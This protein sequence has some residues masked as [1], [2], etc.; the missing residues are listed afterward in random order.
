MK[1]I[2]LTLQAFGPYLEKTVIDFSAF[3]EAGLF[4]ISGP[5]GG[6]KTALLDAV[7]FALYGR[8]TGGRRTF[9]SMRCM[10][11]PQELPTLVEYEFSLGQDTYLFRRTRASHVHRTTKEV[12]LRDSHECY[13]LEEGQWKLLESRSDSAVRSRAESIL[14]ITGDQFSQVIVLP[15]GDFLR[16]LRASSKEKGEMLQT[17]FSAERWKALTDRLSSR[18]RALEDKL[19]ELEARRNSL[20]E[21]EGLENSAALSQAAEDSAK[22]E[23][24]LRAENDTL[25]QQA[26]KAQKELKEAEEWARLLEAKSSGEAKAGEALARCDLLAGQEKENSEKRKQAEALRVQAVKAAQELARLEEKKQ[27]AV[28]A[29]ETARQA[30][31][32]R[33]ALLSTQA[34]LKEF[35]QLSQDRT[36]RLKTGEAYIREC[37]EA[38][39]ALP[40]LLE[41]SHRL[42]KIRSDYGELARRR[43]EQ[44]RAFTKLD[45]AKKAAE[46]KEI[47]LSALSRA[48]AH[49]EEKLRHNTALELARTLTEGTPCPVCGS[50]HHPDPRKGQSGMLDQKELEAL[51]TREKQAREESLSA[52]SAAGAAEAQWKQAEALWK[53]QEALCGEFGISL[54]QAQVDDDALK[55]KLRKTKEKAELLQK[56]QKRMDELNREREEAASREAALREKLSGQKAKAEE[57]ERSA[58][59]ALE[60]LSGLDPEGLDRALKEK[61]EHREELE[62]RAAELQR[63]AELWEADRQKAAEANR[64]AEEALEKVKSDLAAFSGGRALGESPP[65]LPALKSRAAELREESLR[66]SEE[67][68]KAGEA[69]LSLKAALQ[70]VQALEA[71]SGRQEKDYS[72]AARLAR[73]LRGDNSQKLPILQ[74]VLSMM[75][76]EVLASANRFFSNL[77]RGRYRLQLMES[78]RGGNA[79]SGLDLEVA[80][81]A[82]ML[83][84]SIETL[85]GGEQFLASLSLAFGLSEVVQN[86]SGAV[87]MDA[88]FIDEGFGSLDSETLDTA[89]KALGML[90][91]SGR[92]VG[93]ISHVSELK[94]RLPCRIEVTRDEAGFSHAKINT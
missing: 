92:M 24:S 48:L 55:E 53:E 52:G 62:R 65:D 40:A 85:S 86:H 28:K 3:E 43:E 7:S 60:S 81:G 22:R 91:G 8:A 36:K 50:T 68:G 38:S 37:R 19:K 25:R 45:A 94:S 17:L 75:L 18:A 14:H 74:F 9:D 4:L 90:R 69:C 82:S 77:S 83:P 33:R 49:E 88:L 54:E 71:E 5:T 10:G 31:E 63:Q 87:R 21:K 32:A 12:E 73:L 76:E 47:A 15:Q 42:E 78:P 27:A 39:A 46:E 34:E 64:L 66:R 29:A 44:G 2:K 51:R 93:I 35:E 26:E 23:A 56:A 89:M 57:L 20:L 70:A 80:D 72:L 84:R 61:Q 6:G 79:L 11:A 13:T 58:K 67:L 1:P 59:E 30:E 41:E 16:L